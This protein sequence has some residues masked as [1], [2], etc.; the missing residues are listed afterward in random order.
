LGRRGI[1]I[2]PSLIRAR[3]HGQLAR[4]MG[5]EVTAVDLYRAPR[6]RPRGFAVADQHCA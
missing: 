4:M 6:E 3:F 5:Y 2:G 1:H